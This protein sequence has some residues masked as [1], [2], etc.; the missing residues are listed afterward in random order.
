MTQRWKTQEI[1]MSLHVEIDPWGVACLFILLCNVLV[2]GAVYSN[3]RHRDKD[4]D[5]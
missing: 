1:M 2:L 3:A 4:E 5:E